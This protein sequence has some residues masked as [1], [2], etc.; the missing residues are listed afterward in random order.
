MVDVATYHRL[1]GSKLRDL[2]SSRRQPKFDPWPTEYKREDE[3][4]DQMIILLPATVRGFDIQE[5]E[6]ST[7]QLPAHKFD[8]STNSG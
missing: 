5:K 7:Y 4:D 2:S 6:W 1:H 8:R 3:I